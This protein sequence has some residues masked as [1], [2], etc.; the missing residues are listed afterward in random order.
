MFWIIEVKIEKGRE[1]IRDWKENV[2]NTDIKVL[3]WASNNNLK[4]WKVWSWI[5]YIR[6]FL[7][8][9][10]YPRRCFLLT[11]PY[12]LCFLENLS[13]V[14]IVYRLNSSW[15]SSFTLVQFYKLGV[16]YLQRNKVIFTTEFSKD[17]SLCH[18]LKLSNPYIFETQCYALLFQVMNYVRSKS[19]SLKYQ[20]FT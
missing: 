20:K 1:A 4:R 12:F 8:L 5:W 14:C 15:S 19:L 16:I 6:L 13:T 18:K 9:Y 10:Y 17:L 3:S 11:T 2:F 7:H